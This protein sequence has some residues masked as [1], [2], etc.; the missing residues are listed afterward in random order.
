MFSKKPKAAPST[1]IRETLFGDMPLERWPPNDASANS[2]P[3]DNF[4][5]ARSALSKGNKADA[6]GYWQEILKRP[7]VEPRHQLQAWFFLRQQGQQPSADC[8]KQVL[9]VVVEVA[10]EGGLDVLAAYSDHSA[11]Y[12][13]YSGG[14][15]VWE[16]P[17]ESLN[18]SIDELL[19]AATSVVSAIGP[20]DK[21]RPPAPP[22]DHVRMSF[23]TPS[24][25]HFGQGPMAALAKDP[26]GGKVLH[27]ATLL[28]QALTAKTQ[29]T[30]GS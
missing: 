10:L 16:H 6:V 15:V 20:W 19:L 21:P 18:A 30:S 26:L 24:G 11:R 23:L 17:D 4:V 5:A 14:G 1:A 9:G 27:S 7:D 29:S 12:Y 22:H 25:L 2:F 28:M 8:A 3:W 13:N